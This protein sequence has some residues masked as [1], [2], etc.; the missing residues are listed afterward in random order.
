MK[1]RHRGVTVV[2]PEPVKAPAPRWLP[3]AHRFLAPNLLWLLGQY[4]G[5][6]ILSWFLKSTMLWKS[7][8]MGQGD[9]LPKSYSDTEVHSG[10]GCTHSV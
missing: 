6:V 5:S 8:R 3:G 4:L 2:S 9:N 7:L 10:L 1:V